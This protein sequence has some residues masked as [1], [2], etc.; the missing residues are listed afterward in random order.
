M[1]SLIAEDEFI[2][3]QCLY[4]QLSKFGEVK[5]AHNGREAVWAFFEAMTDH[6]PFDLICLDIMMPQMDGLEALKSIRILETAY[7][8]KVEEKT[9]IV[10]MTALAEKERVTQA[11]QNGCNDYMLKPIHSQA[12]VEKLNTLG[13]LN[14]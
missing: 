12:L 11:L 9:A 6:L 8:Q 13:L 2:S 7:I 1:K 14:A 5:I 4:H 10:M 3:R